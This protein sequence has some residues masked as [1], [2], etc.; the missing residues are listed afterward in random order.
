ML[1]W[2][3]HAVT[4]HRNRSNPNCCLTCRAQE[5]VCDRREEGECAGKQGASLDEADELEGSEQL[6]IG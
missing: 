1:A 3:M 2:A 6:E 5:A 4:D